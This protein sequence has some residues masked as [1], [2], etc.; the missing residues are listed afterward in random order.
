[1]STWLREIMFFPDK[2]MQLI[3][4][5]WF[6]VAGL[7]IAPFFCAKLVNLME[8][9]NSPFADSSL[10]RF[11]SKAFPV[12]RGFF[13]IMCTLAALKGTLHLAAYSLVAN[14]LVADPWNAEANK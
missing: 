10:G 1:M 9:M 3:G 2:N 11:Q 7:L 8:W 4:G 14:G 6:L 5:V 12:F 13:S